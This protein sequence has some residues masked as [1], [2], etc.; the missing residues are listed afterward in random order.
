[1]SGA[2]G[3]IR[4]IAQTVMHPQPMWGAGS[5]FLQNIYFNG[6]GLTLASSDVSL[7]IALDGQPLAKLSMSFT[8]AKTLSAYLTSVIERLERV[9]KHTIMKTDEVEAGLKKA[10]SEASST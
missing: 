8:T 3:E 10:D 9:T 6:F 4:G 1:M 5:P 7:M 2:P